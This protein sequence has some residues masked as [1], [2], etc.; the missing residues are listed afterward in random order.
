MKVLFIII[1]ITLCHI[2]GYTQEHLNYLGIWCNNE[3]FEETSEYLYLEIYLDENNKVRS[4]LSTGGPFEESQKLVAL[5]KNS[6]HL[7]Y[8]SNGGSISFN[9]LNHKASKSCLKNPFASCE[10]LDDKHLLMT[11]F[12]NNCSYL[13][14]KQTLILMR[15]ESDESCGTN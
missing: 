15:L 9:Q 14:Q 1:L 7:F 5:S 12:E 8:E 10:V 11:T 6:F 13:P 4:S 2:T 3:R